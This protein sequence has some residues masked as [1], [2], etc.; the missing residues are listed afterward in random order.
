MAAVTPLHSD[1]PRFSL[2]AVAQPVIAGVLLYQGLTGGGAL[3]ILVGLG[4]GFYYLYTRHT[5]YDL[6]EDVLVIRY[7]I[8]TMVVPLTD[9]EGAELGG[10]PMSGQALLI[11]RRGGGLLVM[12][13]KDPE[14]FLSRLNF[15]SR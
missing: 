12:T 15:R 10:M 3:P 7:R 11:R 9:V 5:R 13:P 8:R 14:G 2:W 6:F 4:L 1:T